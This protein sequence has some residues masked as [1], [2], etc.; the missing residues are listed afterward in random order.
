MSGENHLRK[1]RGVVFVS[2]QKRYLL[3]TS[4]LL[5]FARNLRKHLHL[6]KR[7][8]NVCFVDDNAIRQLNLAFRG[9]NK[10]TDVLSFPWQETAGAHRPGPHHSGRGGDFANFLGDIIISVETARRSAE[11]EGHTTLNEIRWLILH[12]VL[13]LLG[14]DH[15]KDKGQMNA[16]ELAL[17]EQLGMAGGPREKGKSRIKSPRSMGKADFL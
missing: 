16:L 8:F 2:L 6:E 7:E 14:Y 1:V 17:R 15:E 4:S 3:R 11:I 13:H 9:K 5:P 12:G 10:A